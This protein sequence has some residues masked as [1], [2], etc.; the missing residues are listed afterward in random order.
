[1]LHWI[2]LNERSNCWSDGWVGGYTD[3][4]IKILGPAGRAGRT[5]RLAV[6]VAGRPS[7]ST[8]RN[9]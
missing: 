5:V 6:K 1:M 4:Q 8:T 9:K 3:R 2:E 7:G